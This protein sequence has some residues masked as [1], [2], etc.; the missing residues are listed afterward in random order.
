[1]TDREEHLW[2][3]MLNNRDKTAAEIAKLAGVP[4][5]EVAAQIARIG[6]PE[7]IWRG[8]NE[9]PHRAQLLDTARDLTCGE[10]N[11]DYGDPVT[12]MND[13]AKLFNTRTGH[14]I[15][16]REVAIMMQ[17]VKQARRATSPTH[18]DSYIDDMAYI[19]IEYECALAEE[20]KK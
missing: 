19:G 16:G 6:T 3:L 7:A 18:K 12:N 14:H 8:T 10:R 9:P 15:S 20:K 5:Q 13:I 2:K 1:M 4:V 11:K 17:C